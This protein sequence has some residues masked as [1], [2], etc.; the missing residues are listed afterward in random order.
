M[1]RESWNSIG[2][3]TPFALAMAISAG[4]LAQNP[5]KPAPTPVLTPAPP[6]D[7]VVIPGTNVD[8]AKKAQEVKKL[9]SAQKPTDQGPTVVDGQKAADDPCEN[10]E[11]QIER[12][13]VLM[14]GR[15]HIA[16]PARRNVV[17]VVVVVMGGCGCH[18][19]P[20]SF[21]TV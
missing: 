13:N 12:A 9:I 4:A 5:P 15:E 8:A 7:T 20:S 1:R 2:L 18:L 16:A 19:F 6:R 3:C 14:V 17:G 11:D 21:E 10:R